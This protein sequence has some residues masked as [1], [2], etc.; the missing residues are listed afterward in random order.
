MGGPREHMCPLGH[1]EPIQVWVVPGILRR[2]LFLST[3]GSED[4]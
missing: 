4:F 2:G 3:P 1:Q